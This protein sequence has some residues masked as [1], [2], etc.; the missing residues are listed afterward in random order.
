MLVNAVF[1]PKIGLFPSSFR[2]R[3]IACKQFFRPFD[4]SRRMLYGL[5]MQSIQAGP[6]STDRDSR[7]SARR[8]QPDR[9]R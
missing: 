2:E 9:P 4:D 5:A 6:E 1:I 7:A 3:K 8:V